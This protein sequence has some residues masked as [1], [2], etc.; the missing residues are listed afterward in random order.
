MSNSQIARERNYD[1]FNGTCLQAYPGLIKW[2]VHWGRQDPRLH[3]HPVQRSNLACVCCHALAI[4]L[5]RALG[6]EPLL[7][8][9]GSSYWPLLL[10]FAGLY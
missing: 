4:A 9:S 10:V 8:V 1:T 2:S 7:P 6:N 3:Q 5:K